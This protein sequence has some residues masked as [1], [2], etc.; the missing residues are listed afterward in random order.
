MTESRKKKDLSG[1][2]L[3]FSFFRTVWYWWGVCN[4]VSVVVSWMKT[5]SRYVIF[6]FLQINGLKM[7]LM[8]E[9]KAAGPIEIP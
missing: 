3:R 7:L 6:L 8:N 4:I 2:A 5:S 1:A 9:G